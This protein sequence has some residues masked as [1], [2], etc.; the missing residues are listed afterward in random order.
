MQDDFSQ[1]PNSLSFL[2]E[3]STEIKATPVNESHDVLISAIKDNE[4]YFPERLA[5]YPVFR[6]P[7]LAFANLTEREIS[8]VNAT[9]AK[10]EILRLS[11]IPRWREDELRRTIS[12]FEQMKVYVTAHLSLSRRGY[13]LDKVTQISKIISYQANVPTQR[14]KRFSL[15]GGGV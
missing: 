11:K 4:R 14:R 15:F 8:T 5:E 7:G 2:D 10:L 3:F 9:L 1:N 6:N 12:E 13:L